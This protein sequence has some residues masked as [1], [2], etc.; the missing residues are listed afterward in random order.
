MRPQK[1]RIVG[2]GHHRCLATGS[3]SFLS[4][5]CGDA[6]FNTRKGLFDPV[7]GVEIYDEMDALFWALF[8]GYWNRILR[9]GIGAKWFILRPGRERQEKTQDSQFC[10]RAHFNDINSSPIRVSTS[11]PCTM[12]NTFNTNIQEAEKGSSLSSRPAWSL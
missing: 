10:S 4:L 7:L 6:Q 3:V 11:M 2:L 1:N 12:A 8:W 5:K 9:T